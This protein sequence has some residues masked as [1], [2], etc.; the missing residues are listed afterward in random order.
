MSFGQRMNM[1]NITF[2]V[3]YCIKVDIFFRLLSGLVFLVVEAVNT[4]FANHALP[5]LF[6]K[7]TLLSGQHILLFLKKR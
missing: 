2:I 3:F 1:C 7:S 4:P 5:V 6:G